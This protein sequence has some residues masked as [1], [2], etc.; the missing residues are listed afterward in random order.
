MKKKQAEKLLD[1]WCSNNYFKKQKGKIYLG[2]RLLCE[3]RE[4]LQSL[5]LNYLRSC[6]LCESV[7]IWVRQSMPE[8]SSN[9]MDAFSFLP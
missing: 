4:L 3:F 6:L 7:A 2:P 5:E 1:S 9:F 8:F